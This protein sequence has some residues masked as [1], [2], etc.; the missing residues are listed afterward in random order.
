VLKGSLSEFT[1]VKKQI[2]KTI[3]I[4]QKHEGQVQVVSVSKNGQYTI[5]GDNKGNVKIFDDIGEIK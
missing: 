1:E 3:P 4:V 2:K 5:T